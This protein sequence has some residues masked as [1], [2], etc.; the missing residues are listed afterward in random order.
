[1]QAPLYQKDLPDTSRGLSAGLWRQKLADYCSNDPQYGLR[2]TEDFEKSNKQTVFA[3]AQLNSAT[4]TMVDSAEPDGAVTLD[5]GATTNHHGGRIAAAACVPTP[6]NSTAANRRGD[7]VFEA[8][9]DFGDAD[10]V[11]VG[12]SESGALL[13]ATSALPADEDF[14]GFYTA[15]NGTT[16]TFY[17]RNDN[18]GGTAVEK[19]YDVS[20]YKQSGYNKLGFRLNKDGS[21]EVGINGY[22]LPK[23]VTGV[24]STSVPIELL[25]PCVEYTN[26]TSGTQATMKVDRI[27]CFVAQA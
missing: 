4:S 8:R 9:V 22:W 5:A 12:L 11:F 15:D 25:A 26:G 18:N 13:G 2:I 10:T 23:A 20:A 1:M 14:V 24:T 16:L 17:C 7:V 6:L 27:D 3:L 21:V 19:T